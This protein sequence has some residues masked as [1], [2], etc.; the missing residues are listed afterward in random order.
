MVSSPLS[1]LQMRANG[2]G[3][4]YPVELFVSRLA[5]REIASGVTTAVAPRLGTSAMHAIS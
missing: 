2:L 4:Q 1:P 5:S 3:W